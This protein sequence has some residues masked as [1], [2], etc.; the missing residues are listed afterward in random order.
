MDSTFV[1]YLRQ[2]GNKEKK[3]KK[4]FTFQQCKLLQNPSWTKVNTQN[5]FILKNLNKGFF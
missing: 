2:T 5:L 3:A 4:V 1:N